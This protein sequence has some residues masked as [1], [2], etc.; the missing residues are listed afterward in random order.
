MDSNYVKH[1]VGPVLT[2]ALTALTMHTGVIEKKIPLKSYTSGP[3]GHRTSVAGTGSNNRPST[4]D[5]PSVA[6]DRVISGG[7]VSAAG[8]PKGFYDKEELIE[9]NDPVEFVA[10]YLLQ[11]EMMA[12]VLEADRQKQTKIRQTHAIFL[13]KE[14]AYQEM[15][16][17]LLQD[18]KARGDNEGAE[19]LAYM[20]AR[21]M[22][23]RDT[24]A[25]AMQPQTEEAPADSSSA[26][27]ESSRA[28]TSDAPATDAIAPVALE[29][30]AAAPAT[31]APAEAVQEQPSQLAPEPKEY[32]AVNEDE[33]VAK[34]GDEEAPLP[35]EDAEEVLEPEPDEE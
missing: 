28:A 9:F 18:I 11:H 30:A 23:R 12:P 25:A 6:G 14:R 24:V 20:R 16:R 4:T 8:P 10:R 3:L 35:D 13:A 29:P 17:R 22:T 7:L 34:A 5:R 31:V 26:S 32:P 2:S 33:A 21:R 15:K 1:T 19:L 27:N